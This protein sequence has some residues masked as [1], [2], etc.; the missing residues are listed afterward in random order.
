MKE[1][2]QNAADPKVPILSQEYRL[3]EESYKTDWTSRT[4]IPQE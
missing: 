1:C 3:M 2:G 4:Q